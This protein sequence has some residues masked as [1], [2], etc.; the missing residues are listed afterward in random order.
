MDKICENPQH[1]R[2]RS[3]I[4]LNKNLDP[5]KL[6]DWPADQSTHAS[7]TSRS[8]PTRTGPKTDK[9]EGQ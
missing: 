6:T 4:T 8:T 5:K 9:K 2:R 7:I 1:D 3:H